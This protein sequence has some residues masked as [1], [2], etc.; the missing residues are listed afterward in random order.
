[1]CISKATDRF[2]SCAREALLNTEGDLFNIEQVAFVS[3]DEGGRMKDERY[4][5][6]EEPFNIE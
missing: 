4:A 3:K 5:I 2:R 1:L 6:H